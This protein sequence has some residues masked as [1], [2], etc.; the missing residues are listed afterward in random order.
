MKNRTN[1]TLTAV[2]AALMCLS[3]LLGSCG[4]R[5]EGSESGSTG[6]GSG[7]TAGNHEYVEP[8][9]GFNGIDISFSS[10]NGRKLDTDRI[11]D[12]L[13]IMNTGAVRNT[14]NMT[15][16]LT[17]PATANEKQLALQKSWISRLSESG[18]NKI[19]AVSCGWFHTEE[20]GITDRYAAPAMER[21]RRFGFQKMACAL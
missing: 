11:A 16:V 2:L 21:C 18:I 20:S 10:A 12:L 9:N 1:R 5:G 4:G 14:V 17:D 8:E 13:G 7:S 3:P 19:I 15:T 6:G